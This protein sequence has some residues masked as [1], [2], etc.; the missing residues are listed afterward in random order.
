MLK[1]RV[2]GQRLTWENPD[3]VVVAGTKKYLEC[4]FEFDGDAWSGFEYIEV[5]FKNGRDKPI[6]MLLSANRIWKE[7]G[8]CLTAGDWSVYLCATTY[9]AEKEEIE[10][11]I[12][13]S[14]VSIRVLAH[15]QFEDAQNSFESPEI[16]NQYIAAMQ[17]FEDAREKAE[18]ERVEAENAR[19]VFEEYNPNKTYVK[20]NKVSY[21]GSSYVLTADEASGI[22]P[23]NSGYWLCIAEKGDKGEQGVQG[24]K[25]DKGDKGKDGTLWISLYFELD[26]KKGENEEAQFDFSRNILRFGIGEYGGLYKNDYPN[27]YEWAVGDFFVSNNGKILQIKQLEWLNSELLNVDVTC[28]LEHDLTVDQ[29]FDG[30]S[31]NA[32]SGKALA[33]VLKA[34]SEQVA[35]ADLSNVSN[36]AFARKAEE[37]GVGGGVALGNEYTGNIP[38]EILYNPENKDSVTFTDGAVECSVGDYIIAKPKVMTA[39]G[40]ALTLWVCS[41]VEDVY[42]DGNQ[43][44]LTFDRKFSFSEALPAVGEYTDKRVLATEGGGLPQWVEFPESTAGAMVFKGFTSDFPSSP[45]EGE[46]YKASA[47]LRENVYIYNNL[48]YGT[49]VYIDDTYVVGLADNVYDI[50]ADAVNEQVEIVY[51]AYDGEYTYMKYCYAT[52]TDADISSHRVEFENPTES[53]SEVFSS[54]LMSI[55]YNKTAFNEGDLIIYHNGEWVEISKDGVTKTE[56]ESYIEETL[57]G[58]EW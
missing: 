3:E 9:N 17:V 24:I 39:F 27:V 37:A 21:E 57:L 1:F 55:S 49:P 44:K 2:E 31:E 45:T 8:L 46:V 50:F 12:T 32:V 53:L 56:M 35:Y 10:R 23:P 7:D 13:S 51:E 47:D 58:G 4:Y 25:G 40:N 41:Y 5:F 33:E 48:E 26:I 52:V 11:Q 20:G 36:E 15:G 42:G 29:V 22:V 54:R 28:I 43:Y 30:D 18:D 38:D 19:S 14:S 6:R 34:I 16:A